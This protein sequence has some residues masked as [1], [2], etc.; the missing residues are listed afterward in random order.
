MKVEV[1]VVTPI[2]FGP[3]G[4]KIQ[5]KPGNHEIEEEYLN[6]FAAEAYIASGDLVIKKKIE[7]AFPVDEEKLTQVEFPEGKEPVIV[8]EETE[9]N[10]TEPPIVITENKVE[11]KEEPTPKF[12]KIKT[13]KAE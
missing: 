13:K 4:N 3:K 11:S 8:V 5:L 7:P 2:G 10:K 1:I 9:E 6:C 12:R